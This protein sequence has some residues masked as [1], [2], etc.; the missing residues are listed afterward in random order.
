MPG[1]SR[2]SASRDIVPKW[3]RIGS[4]NT[5]HDRSCRQLVAHALGIEGTRAVVQLDD[6]PVPGFL[7]IRA[8]VDEIPI[9]VHALNLLCFLKGRR[10]ANRQ[11]HEKQSDA[12]LVKFADTGT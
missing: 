7:V 12:H 9:A 6:V 11:A 8:G 4:T 10:A 2:L 3:W 1:E 5:H